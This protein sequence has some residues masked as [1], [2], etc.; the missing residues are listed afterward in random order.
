MATISSLITQRDKRVEELFDFCRK[1]KVSQIPKLRK[2]LHVAE[3]E[4][5]ELKKKE[6]ENGRHFKQQRKV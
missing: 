5:E 1:G 4:L 3:D 2:L 6:Q